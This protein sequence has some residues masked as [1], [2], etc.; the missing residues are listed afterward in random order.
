MCV[1]AAP[2]WPRLSLVLPPPSFP[3]ADPLGLGEEASNLSRF[4][5][6]E[7]IHGRWAMLGAAGVLAVEALGYGNWYDAPLPV[8]NGGQATYF[9]APIPFSFGTLAGVVRGARG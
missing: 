3:P 7:V 2:L 4:T 9:G 6:S 8:V 1:A 5:E